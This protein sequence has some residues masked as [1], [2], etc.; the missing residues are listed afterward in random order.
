MAAEANDL[1]TKTEVLASGARQVAV[2]LNIEL[3]KWLCQYLKETLDLVK[4][5]LSDPSTRGRCRKILRELLKV[6]KKVNSLVRDCCYNEREETEFIIAAIRLTDSAERFLLYHVEL[7]WCRFL[8]EYMV[9]EDSAVKDLGGF[10][11]NERLRGDTEFSRAR[12]AD[13]FHMVT[14][15]NN[16]L[17]R[18]GDH[19]RICKLLL[20][21]FGYTVSLDDEPVPSLSDITPIKKGGQASV[22]KVKW[23]DKDF[24][25]KTFDNVNDVKAFRMEVDVFR[26]CSHPHILNMICS[27]EENRCGKIMMDLMFKD[28]D[29]HINGKPFNEM[30]YVDMILQVAQGMSYLHEQNVAHRDLKP[31]NI[32]LKVDPED[33]MDPVLKVADFGL[34]RIREY[35]SSLSENTPNVGTPR[36]RAPEL[37]QNRHQ[38]G[39]GTGKVKVD[40]FKADVFSFAITC[41]WILTGIQP[42]GADNEVQF[43]ELP[44]QIKQGTRPY[45]PPE[46]NE[47]LSSLIRRC[48]DLTPSERPSFAVICEELRLLK[49]TLLTGT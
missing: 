20:L 25:L 13:R 3:H 28:L 40:T 7:C 24:A 39:A 49:A 21:R 44:N 38:E 15:L 16:S 2:N 45:L 37:Y 11:W 34:A 17:E 10:N 46:C 27:F 19:R 48:W 47:T 8:V 1:L 35:L 31:H 5:V 41:S 36:Y 12:D 33:V 30:E 23:K 18:G 43:S 6:A 29:Q 42:Y 4:E 9:K 32:L 14:K 22:W 26:T